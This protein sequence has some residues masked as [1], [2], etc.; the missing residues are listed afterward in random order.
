MAEAKSSKKK[1]SPLVFVG[2][3]CVVLIVLISLGSLIIGKF[4]AKKIGT[5]LLETSI[6]KQTGVKTSLQDAEDGKMTFTDEKTGAKVE[7]GTGT[8]PETF[9][10]DFPLY[11]GAKATSALSGAQSGK[12]DGFWLTMTTGDSLSKVDGFY[13]SQLPAKGWEITTTY[14]SGDT[15]SRTVTKGAWSGSVAVTEN[16]ESKETDIVIILGQE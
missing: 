5:G 3:G 2:I 10:K 9:P 13:K 12:S 15:T 6:E 16:S 4:F 7:I 8:I 1:T 14:S 11:P